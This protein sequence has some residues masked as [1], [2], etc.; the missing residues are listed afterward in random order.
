MPDLAR[1]R[2]S[3]V[4][5]IELSP[6]LTLIVSRLVALLM[7]VS[8]AR[9]KATS[10][11]HGRLA[12]IVSRTVRIVRSTS[13]VK[14]SEEHTSELLSLLRHSYAVFCLNKTKQIHNYAIRNTVITQ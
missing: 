6:R 13:G 10:I 14:R 1:A 3:S 2:S 9:P 12:R 7:L 4:S 11:C 8:G 5:G